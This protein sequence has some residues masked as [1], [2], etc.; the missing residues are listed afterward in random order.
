[1]CGRTPVS[2]RT[3]TPAGC[4]TTMLDRSTSGQPELEK[5]APGRPRPPPLTEAP[6]VPSYETMACVLSDR[7]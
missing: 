1:M 2:R 5:L 4:F 7:S 3:G 6:T